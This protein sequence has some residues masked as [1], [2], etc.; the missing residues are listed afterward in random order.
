M[1]KLIDVAK[2]AKTPEEVKTLR[3]GAWKKPVVGDIGSDTG[4]KLTNKTAEEKVK[5]LRLER[6]ADWEVRYGSISGK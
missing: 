4:K 6:I 5:K 1:S 2:D 3:K